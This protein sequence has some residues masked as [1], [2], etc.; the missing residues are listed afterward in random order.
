MKVVVAVD[1]FKGSLSSI[2]AGNAVRDGIHKAL[3]AEVSVCPIA[4]GGEGTVDALVTGMG[5]SF[6]LTTVTGPLGEPVLAK[7]GIIE[8]TGEKT[9][10]IEMAEAAGIVLLKKEELN[11]YKTTT[12][13]V[14]ELIKA[15]ISEGCKRFIIGIGGSATNDGGA[16]MLQALGFELTDAK[17]NEIERGAIG[18]KALSGISDENAVVGLKDCTIRVACDV[19]NPLCGNS[20]CSAVYGPQ[21]GATPEMIA[22]MDVWLANYAT[23]SGGD[24]S[25]PGTG[26]AG[27]LGFAFRTFLGAKLEPGIDI[28]LEET[29]LEEKIKEAD[30]VITGEGRMDAQTIMGKAPVG[31]AG[32]ARKYNKKVLAFCGC[33]TDDAGVVNEHGIDAYFPITRSIVSLE[34][35]LDKDNARKNMINTVEQVF[36]VLK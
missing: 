22:N 20:G 25:Y 29:E 6:R 16:G 18:L 26:A 27:G 24:A 34:E 10:I 8:A 23:I 13:G 15:G 17:G 11:P 1:S 2:E 7:W 33:A 5:G 30:I 35:A 14:G 12:Y 4:D 3:E 36:R 21:K 31:V 32:I 28:V 9:A 19:K